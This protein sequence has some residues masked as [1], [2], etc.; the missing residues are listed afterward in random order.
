MGY[1]FSLTSA[2][3]LGFKVHRNVLVSRYSN[4]IFKVRPF[5][6]PLKGVGSQGK[7]D[8]MMV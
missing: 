2:N 1:V 6:P 7:V 4:D 5:V 8:K 3:I